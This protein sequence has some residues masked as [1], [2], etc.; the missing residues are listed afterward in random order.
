MLSHGGVVLPRR[1]RWCGFVEGS[2]SV[3][4]GPVSECLFT[5]TDT[6][7]DRSWC[8]GD[9]YFY[10]RPD[11]VI[12]QDMNYGLGRNAVESFKQGLTGHPGRSI[13]DNGPECGGL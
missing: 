11:H 9:G 6:D 1:I 4:V 7:Q 13:Q 2:M 10:D 3:W 8:Q 12:W 5:E